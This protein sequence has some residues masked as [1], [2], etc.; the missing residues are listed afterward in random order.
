[1]QAMRAQKECLLHISHSGVPEKGSHGKS[2]RPC[3]RQIANAALFVEK[4]VSGVVGLCM[5]LF[6]TALSDHGS[7]PCA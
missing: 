5:V 4:R 3:P 7:E 2:T 1:M 6:S